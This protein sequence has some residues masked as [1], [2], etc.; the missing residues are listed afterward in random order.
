MAEPAPG[1]GLHVLFYGREEA[2]LASQLLLLKP[3][4]YRLRYDVRGAPPG[5]AP[6]SW[7]VNCLPANSR[8]AEAPLVSGSELA[9][10]VPAGCRAQELQLRGAIADVPANLDLT[11]G[12]LELV[13][14]DAR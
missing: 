6:L 3:G 4:R 8:L 2:V 1:G 7:A 12:Q 11:I 9:F 14:E 5:E 10:A 13:R